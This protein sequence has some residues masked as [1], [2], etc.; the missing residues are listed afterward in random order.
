MAPERYKQLEQDTSLRLTPEEVADGWHFC[1]DFDGLLI[2]K[3]W[4]E[5]EVCTCQ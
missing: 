4:P 2:H 3:E 1:H 5:A